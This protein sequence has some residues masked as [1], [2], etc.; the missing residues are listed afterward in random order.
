MLSDNSG[1]QSLPDVLRSGLLNTSAFL[2]RPRELFLDYSFEKFRPDVVAGL[3]VA[4]V[5]IPQA[6]AYALIAELPPHMGL[7]AAVV[8]SIV[9][10]LWGSSFH[11]HTGPTNAVSL[12]VLSTLLSIV[13]PGSPEFLALAGLMA[14]MVGITQLVMGLARMGVLVNFVSDSVIVGFTAGAGILIS[15]NQLPHL[16]LLPVQV[17]PGVPS[18]ITTMMSR[19]LEAHG[20]SLT[21]GL[22]TIAVMVLIRTWRPRW[23]A[24]FIAMVMAAVAVALLGLEGRGVI[25]LSELPRALPKLARLP[26]FDLSLIGK[27][28]AGSLAVSAIG[29]VEAMSISRSV[30]SETGQR[31]DSNQE[32]VGQGLAN[33]AA[34]VFSGFTCS[35]SFTRTIVN[36]SSGARTQMAS[37]FSGLWVLAAM[38]LFAPLAVYLPRAALAG[39][40]LVIA[41]RMVNLV[42]VR[43]ILRTSIGDSVIMVS[44]LLATVFLPLE[45]AVLAGVLV[46]FGRFLVK[47]STPRVVP[48][49]PDENFRYFVHEGERPA[50]PQLGMIAIE[51]PLYF[52]AVHHVDEVLHANR[53]RHPEQRLLLLRLHQ[54][55]HCDVSGIHMLEAVVRQYR[56]H[57]GDVYL[58][59]T[60]PQVLEMMTSSGFEQMI[61]SDHLLARDRAVNFLFH[62][63]LE[64]SVCIYEC[65]RRVFAECQAL[66]KHPSTAS[67]RIPITVSDHTVRQLLPGNLK[68]RLDADVSAVELID[69]REEKEY[70]R[71]H[72]YHARL[73]PLPKL[74]EKGVGLPHDRPIVFVCR[75]GRRSMHASYILQ[76]MGYS[77]VYSLRGGMVAWEAEGFPVVTE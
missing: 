49:V 22:G 24:G 1:S 10:A 76:D 6:I 11:L 71:G 52:G 31:L 35:G 9:G 21:L 25:V 5:V 39:V 45:F 65:E 63:V 36:R 33:I 37:V 47:T 57:G 27:L 54:V 28:S 7:Y 23:P 41:S 74:V 44:T 32:F 3:T 26:V 4:M 72:V 15:I 13:G 30:A 75:S 59:G 69:V 56:D 64:P 66:P 12:L 14:V 60:R 51:G 18:V 53:E 46:S 2:A 34:G 16:L 73:L 42:E 17:S 77:D 40:L 55:D 67:L 70:L 38:L 68:S 29:L 8:A 61:G 50:C 43:R 48:V 19:L 20:Y 62:N 58:V